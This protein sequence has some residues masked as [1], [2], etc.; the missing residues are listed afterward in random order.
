MEELLQQATNNMANLNP[1][2][3]LLIMAHL[4][5][6]SDHDCFVPEVLALVIKCRIKQ[7][8]RPK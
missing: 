3:R 1:K 6:H 8:G 5:W 2:A 4:H 7:Y